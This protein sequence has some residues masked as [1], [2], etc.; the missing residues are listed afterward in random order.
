MQPSLALVSIFV[1]VEFLF[2]ACAAVGDSF[3][4]AATWFSIIMQEQRRTIPGHTYLRKIEKFIN[5][6]YKEGE[7]FLS[8]L[9]KKKLEKIVLLVVNGLDHP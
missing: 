5:E 9:V 3:T 4:D 8:C 2:A 1:V 7:N 6:H